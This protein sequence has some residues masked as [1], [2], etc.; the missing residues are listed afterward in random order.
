MQP[1]PR[2]YS[3]GILG[4]VNRNQDAGVLEQT[5]RKLV[6]A[7]V[8]NNGALFSQLLNGSPALAAASFSHGA[9]RQGPS[10][11]TNFIEEIG[12]YIYAGDTALHFAA[13]A[14]RHKMAEQLIKSGADVRAKNRRGGEPLHAAAFGRPGSPRWNP[15]SQAATIAYLI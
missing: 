15:A 10:P 3:F 14:Y 13:A 6:D 8:G 7:L 5:L 1:L 11:G 9:T 12:H 2:I 4:L